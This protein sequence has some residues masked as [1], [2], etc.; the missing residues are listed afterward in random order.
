MLERE[1]E[2]Q[3]LEIEGLGKVEAEVA[4]LE[5]EG[6]YGLLRGAISHPSISSAPSPPKKACHIPSAPSG[7][8]RYHTQS[9]WSCNKNG[10]TGIGGCLSSFRGSS[11]HQHAAP[12]HSIR[13]HQK[14]VQMLVWRLHRGTINLMCYNLHTCAQSALLGW[15]WCV[16]LVANCSSTQTHSGTTR[17][18]ILISKYH[19]HL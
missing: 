13:G 3:H 10:R 14:G 4:G 5:V 17:K 12:L 1:E 19:T 7:A 18:V 8:Y 15:G 16:P 11:P 6:L 2:V 9:L